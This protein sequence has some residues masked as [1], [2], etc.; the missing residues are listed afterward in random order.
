MQEM[1]KVLNLLLVDSE[2]E[3]VPER[4]ASHPAVHINAKK[5][6][7]QAEKMLLDSSLHHSA[8]KRLSQGE[9][10]GRPDIVHF[11]LM[12][13]LESVLNR[14]DLLRVYVHTRNDE[15][16]TFD[17]STRLPKNYPRFVGL[18]ES[19]FSEG[20]APSR[21]E[22]LLMLHKDYSF[23]RC[24]EVIPH[25]RV[26]VLSPDGEKVRLKSYFKGSEDMLCIVGGFSKG[27]FKS[28]VRSNA[29]EII[30]IYDESLTAWTVVSELIVN[31]ENALDKPVH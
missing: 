4:I 6:G 8:M 1:E 18:M 31:Y 10:R 17:P 27:D 9:R 14:R 20:V 26:V 21:G 16:I 25:S 23:E 12:L 2:I 11:V 5:R 15:F 24:I 7:K 3:L 30:S 28:D 13:A 19:L 29:D 22:P